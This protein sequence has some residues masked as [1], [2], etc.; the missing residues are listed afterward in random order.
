MEMRP[1]RHNAPGERN[2]AGAA[3]RHMRALALG[4]VIGA[5]AYGAMRV[6]A[7]ALQW[8]GIGA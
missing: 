1:G 6:L 8:L 2:G 7:A 3:M 5:V 4:A